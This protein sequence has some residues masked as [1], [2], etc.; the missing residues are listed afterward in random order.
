MDQRPDGDNEV[1]GFAETGGWHAFVLLVG[2]GD[3]LPAAS[4]IFRAMASSRHAEVKSWGAVPG[5]VLMASSPSQV[6]HTQPFWEIFLNIAGNARLWNKK[7]E[8]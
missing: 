5:K 3:T 8:G 2:Q 6:L 7:N 1:L 4:C